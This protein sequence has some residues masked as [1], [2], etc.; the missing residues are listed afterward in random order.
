MTVGVPSSV[1]SRYAR[2]SLYNS[3]YPHTT[4]AVR[5]TSTGDARGRAHHGRPSPSPASSA[6]RGRSARRRNPTRPRTI[7]SFSSTATS[8]PNSRVDRAY[9]PRRA[10]GRGRRPRR[11]GRLARRTR[12]RGLFAP[13]STTTSTLAFAVPTRTSGGRRGRSGSS[14][15]SR[16]DRSRGMEPERWSRPARRTPFSTRPPTR[17]RDRSSSGSESVVGTATTPTGSRAFS[18]AGSPLRRRRPPRD[19]PPANA[20]VSDH[21][22]PEGRSRSP[23]NESAPSR[24][25]VG[26]STGTTSS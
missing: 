12:P 3:P 2:F 8:R 7:T 4:A 10:G 1:L 15:T 9:P 22:T 13:G 25:T 20:G 19:E 16:S 26:R 24:R 21:G 11:D 5:S 17:I 23:A 18:T 14:R 6:R